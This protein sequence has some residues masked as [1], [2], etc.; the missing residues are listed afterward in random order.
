MIESVKVAY[1]ED[2]STVV[3]FYIATINN[4]TLGVPVDPGNTEYIAIQQWLAE[5]N[6]PLP[7][8]EQ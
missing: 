2:D 5:G 4:K 7:A 6:E 1:T 8:D 3:S